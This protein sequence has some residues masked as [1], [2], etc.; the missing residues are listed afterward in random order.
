MDVSVSDNPQALASKRFSIEIHVRGCGQG[1]R[2]FCYDILPAELP[3]TT[4]LERRSVVQSLRQLSL[5]SC[6]DI[7]DAGVSILAALARLDHIGA[8]KCSQLT[9]GCVVSL[10]CMTQLKYLGIRWTLVSDAGAAGIASL[11][12]LEYLGLRWCPD[13]TDIGVAWTADADQTAAP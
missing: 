12:H 9:D 7:T 11:Y 13:I 1:S 10:C 8:S 5:A 6:R 4:V 2:L 3:A